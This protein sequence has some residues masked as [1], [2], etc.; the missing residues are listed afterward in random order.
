MSY[1]DSMPKVKQ[2]AAKIREL[3]AKI[4]ELEKENLNLTQMLAYSVANLPHD[5][6]SESPVIAQLRAHKY[7]QLRRAHEHEVERAEERG[8][9]RV[10]EIAQDAWYRGD[11]L[12]I[13][14]T[15]EKLMQLWK[16][17]KAK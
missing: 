10:A 13:F 7:E 6:K 16:E 2:D 3:R 12:T 8:A 14:Q 5:E 15:V 9:R 11:D 17:S 1:E 4:A